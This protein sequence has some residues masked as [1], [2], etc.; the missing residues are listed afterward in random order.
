MA[1]P[2]ERTVGSGEVVGFVDSMELVRSLLH[3]AKDKNNIQID[4]FLG[5][6]V[7]DFLQHAGERPLQKVRSSDSVAKVL[8]IF[9]QG[10]HRVAV[11]APED[12]QRVVGFLSQIDLVRFL[13][14]NNEALKTIASRTVS[15]LRLVKQW[16]LFV[17]KADSVLKAFHKMAEHNVTAI[18]VTDGD[19]RLCEKLTCRAVQLISETSIRAIN[20]PIHDFLI[21]AGANL[22]GR[23]L[24]TCE[25]S[26]TYVQVLKALVESGEHRVWVV[27]E[28]H[29]PIGVVSLTDLC[30]VIF[31]E[32]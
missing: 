22:P 30:A 6:T 7:A 16:V 20:R 15:R 11:V 27:D 23:E 3:F 32:E 1:L 29:K 21:K 9:S 31:H 13:L 19:G 25:E 2:V 5:Q 4:R 26:T 12:L 14:E 18:A 17:D 24:L 10:V 28:H 8:S